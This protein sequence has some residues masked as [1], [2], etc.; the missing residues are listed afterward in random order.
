M[1]QFVS[2]ASIGDAWADAYA[3]LVTTGSVVN[4]AV[5]IREPLTEDLGVRK[6]IEQHLSNQRTRGG[7]FAS[8][9]SI[10]TVAN[11]LFPIGLY[12][13]GDA[14]SAARFFANVQRG[15]GLRRHRRSS[16]WGT[17]IGRLVDFPS[18]TGQGVNQLEIAIARLRRTKKYQDIYE[19]PLAPAGE[20]PS[21]EVSAV[22]HRDC[23]TDSRVRG[24]PCLAHISLTRTDNTLSMCAMYRRHSYEARAYGNFLGL[25][26]LL[27]FLAAES[28]LEVGNLLVV[29]SHAVADH[30]HRDELLDRAVGAS[31]GP[32][33]IELN[34]RA[35]GAGWG[36]LDLPKAST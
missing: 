23:A 13:P 24:G 8:L 17:Y 19:M 26:R 10:H 15:E 7:D 21:A 25:A 36:D 12:R 11:T 4:L 18:E 27:N 29:A 32:S 31:T 2:G 16:G 20:P 34:A 28:N 30:T 5:E 1:A 14:G 22:L 6:S 9:Q 35:L 3:T 33:P